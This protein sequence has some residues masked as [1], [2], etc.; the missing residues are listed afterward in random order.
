MT[1]LDVASWVVGAFVT[2]VLVGHIFLPPRL[3]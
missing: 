2:G 3:S 1:A